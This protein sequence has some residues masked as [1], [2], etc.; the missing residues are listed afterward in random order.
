M[1]CRH[2]RIHKHALMTRCLGLGLLGAA[3]CGYRDS[4]ERTSFSRTAAL[5]VDSAVDM[6][7]LQHGNCPQNM[8][9]L[10]NE[11]ILSRSST[12]DAWGHPFAVACVASTGEVTVSSTGPD[13]RLGT[14]DD[15]LG[16]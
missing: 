6:Y 1:T 5:V 9:T 11:G 4:Q 8:E 13:G 10:V 2:Q 16:K 15:I 7:V 3:S 12:K 14:S